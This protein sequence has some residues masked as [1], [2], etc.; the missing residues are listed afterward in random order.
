MPT[1]KKYY[2]MI[3]LKNKKKNIKKNYDCNFFLDVQLMKQ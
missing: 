1:L 2:E 3:K